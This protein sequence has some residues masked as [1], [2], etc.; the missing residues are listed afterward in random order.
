VFM[1][2]QYEVP[3]RTYKQRRD[4]LEEGNRI[5]SL[6]AQFKKD[7]KNGKRSVIEILL[8][9]PVPK[10]FA[11]MRV[12]EMMLPLPKLGRVKIQ[13][14]LVEARIS[15][16]KTAAGLTARQRRELASWLVKYDNG[17]GGS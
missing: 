15:P 17:G 10:D 9:D 6:R 8:T 13:K 2:M 5:R 7:V 14:M 16:S 11:T 3:E 1:E 4:A 12:V